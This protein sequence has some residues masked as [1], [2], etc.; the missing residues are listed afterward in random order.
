MKQFDPAKAAQIWQR[1]RAGMDTS[2][3]A[4][5]APGLPPLPVYT[6]PPEAWIP[7]EKPVRTPR[8]V[9]KPSCTG[10][11]APAWIYLV[12]ICLLICGYFS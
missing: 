10:S 5:P 2:P 11:A 6:T 7:A 4:C 8:V 3:G 9:Q 12:V 1:V